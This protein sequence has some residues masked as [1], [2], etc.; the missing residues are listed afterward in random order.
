MKLRQLR[1]LFLEKLEDVEGLLY[2]EKFTK[3]QFWK[4]TC[5]ISKDFLLFILFL[6][7]RNPQLLLLNNQ[8][9]ILQIVRTQR[10]CTI[11]KTKRRIKNPNDIQLI[12]T[13]G[14]TF[15]NVLIFILSFHYA[16]H[17]KPTDGPL[18]NVTMHVPPATLT[19]C[20]RRYFPTNPSPDQST[21]A[22]VIN[23]LSNGEENVCYPPRE[24]SS[25]Y[26]FERSP[27]ERIEG[28]WLEQ[29]WTLIYR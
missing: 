10:V 15:R 8:K 9:D 2:S 21:C 13:D 7:K 11:F 23:K 19:S 20:R 3:I 25:S 5:D 14:Y 29:N 1:Q 22:R 27:F 12:I 16:K 24:K 28:K 6:Y 26:K 17:G 4:R 18:S